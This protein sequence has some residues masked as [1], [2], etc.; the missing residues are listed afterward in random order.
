MVSTSGIVHIRIPRDDA[1]RLYLVLVALQDD[2]A[3]EALVALEPRLHS[4]V[5]RIHQALYE[6][7]ARC[8][9]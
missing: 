4:L 6:A 8:L 7:Q 9:L 2:N 3:D 5:A 1:M